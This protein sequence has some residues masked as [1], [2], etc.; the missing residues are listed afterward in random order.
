MLLLLNFNQQFEA[1]RDIKQHD[2]G[3]YFSPNQRVNTNHVN[4]SIVLT[5]KAKTQT[6][7]IAK[8]KR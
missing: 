4:S 3:A 1:A 8:T 5:K 2:T 6:T 7:A